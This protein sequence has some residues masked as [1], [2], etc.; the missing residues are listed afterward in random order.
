MSVA[1]SPF[2]ANIGPVV[3]NPPVQTDV[4]KTAHERFASAYATRA[5]VG[6][7]LGAV[8]AGP[9]GQILLQLIPVLLQGCM[10]GVNGTTA[11]GLVFKAKN[12]SLLD[13]LSVQ[14]RTR[15]FLRDS[16]GW[17]AWRAY[18]GPSIVNAAF[19]AAAQS[20]EAEV[21]QLWSQVQ[22]LP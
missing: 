1:E 10:S 5:G 2:R 12:P 8:L 14:H 4:L 15:L 13:Q 16:Y 21:G 11:G 9:I 17:G 22:N 19:D 6:G 20:D 3:N 7:G 18:D